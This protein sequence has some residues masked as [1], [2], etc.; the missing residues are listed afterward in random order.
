MQYPEK[1]T[2]RYR[3]MPSLCCERKGA[4]AAVTCRHWQGDVVRGKRGLWRS[5]HAKMS[6][7]AERGTVEEHE[8]VKPHLRIEV[9]PLK[10][11]LHHGRMGRSGYGWSDQGR[12]YRSDQSCFGAES[13]PDFSRHRP[14]GHTWHLDVGSHDVSA[15]RS[16][17][18]AR[19]RRPLPAGWRIR[20]PRRTARRLRPDSDRR[21]DE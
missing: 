19:R 11:L 16:T 10:V 3:G 5:G 6:L 8:P 20:T 1:L 7:Q 12:W 9:S 18:R 14:T 21:L 15:R 17:R 13:A 4:E 2:L